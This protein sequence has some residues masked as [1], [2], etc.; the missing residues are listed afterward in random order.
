MGRSYA[1]GF[2]TAICSPIISRLLLRA[3]GPANIV[4][5]GF[6][7]AERAKQGFVFIFK[8]NNNHPGNSKIH[9]QKYYPLPAALHGYL[10]NAARDCT[11]LPHAG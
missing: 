7:P 4:A 2:G 5:P 9:F 6:N 3:V 10:F 11:L 1:S 8:P